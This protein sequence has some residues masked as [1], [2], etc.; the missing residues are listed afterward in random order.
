MSFTKLYLANRAATYLPATIRGAWDQTTGAVNFALDP[1]KTGGALTFKGA[2]ETNA[3]DNFDVLLARG[4][5][6][7]LAAQTISGTV[8]VIIGNWESNADANYHWHIHIYATQGDSDTPRGTLLSDY[9]EAAGVNEYTSGATAAGKA[10]N[11]AQTLSS[12]AI[13]AGDRIVVEIGYVSHNTHTTSREGRIYYGCGDITLGTALP[14]LTVGQDPDAG[15]YASFITFSNSITEV[16]VPVRVTQIVAETLS[17]QAAAP[18]FRVTQLVVETLS[19]RS[20]PQ[21]GTGIDTVSVAESVQRQL[22]SVISKKPND[23]VQ[24]LDAVTALLLGQFTRVEPVSAVDSIK[25]VILFVPGLNVEP[26]TLQEFV[27]ASFNQLTITVAEGITVA[28]V[29]TVTNLL[30]VNV[31]EAIT[32]ADSLRFPLN[33]KVFDAIE[34]FDSSKEKKKNIPPTPVVVVPL[35]VV[36]VRDTITASESQLNLAGAGQGGNPDPGAGEIGPPPT[37][38]AVQG[39]YWTLGI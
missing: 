12:L 28:D 11:T 22:R 3:A 18:A 7:P 14:D 25:A 24:V 21:V 17:A 39:D 4:V 10:L 27:K 23:V 33:Q 1:T 5:T 31:S 38:V 13:S 34:A 2:N 15:G 26:V 36:N 8:D 30:T 20:F 9:V 35:L 19:V 37:P 16:D 6:G 32:V 29:R